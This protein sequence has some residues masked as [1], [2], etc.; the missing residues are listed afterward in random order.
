M[1]VWWHAHAAALQCAIMFHMITL[2]HVHVSPGHH[3]AIVHVPNAISISINKVKF[4]S[5]VPC[6]HGCMHRAGFQQP[7]HADLWR[8]P[9]PAEPDS[10]L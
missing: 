6:A 7:I 2:M 3:H 10:R 1:Y 5:L 9:N 8:V 4:F